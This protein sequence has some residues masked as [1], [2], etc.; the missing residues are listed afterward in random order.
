MDGRACLEA[1]AGANVTLRGLVMIGG[2]EIVTTKKGATVS[3]LT[4]PDT[5]GWTGTVTHRGQGV[6]TF[7]AGCALK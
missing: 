7:P 5:I 1:E 4:C 3:F 2:E 6:M